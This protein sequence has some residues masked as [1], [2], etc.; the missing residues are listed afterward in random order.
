MEEHRRCTTPPRTVNSGTSDVGA[1]VGVKI[2]ARLEQELVAA[3]PHAVRT[4]AQII[5]DHS[6]AEEAVGEAL[7]AAVVHVSDGGTI[8]HARAWLAQTA[9]YKAIDLVRARETERKYLARY[10]SRQA[11][12]T[13]DPT[14]VVDDA[15][16]ANWFRREARDLPTGTQRVLA[17]LEQADTTAEVAA[18]LGTSKRAVDSQLYRARQKL[19]TVWATTLGILLGIGARFRRACTVAAPTTA[20]AALTLLTLPLV[21]ATG[22]HSKDRTAPNPDAERSVVT[23]PMTPS[24]PLTTQPPAV[25]SSPQAATNPTS[26]PTPMQRTIVDIQ[27]PVNHPRAY[28]TTRPGSEDPILGTL[29][30][31]E[32]IEV[33]PGTHIG[34]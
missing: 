11:E 34:C 8:S 10:A 6:D 18:H 3:M 14:V 32:Q 31:V 1:L 21:T 17:E 15:S 33:K 13:D 25:G 4:C 22:Q 24:R 29:E 27:T 2:P 7:E 20:L 28:E 5:G 12:T 26:A 9:A 30:C 23:T 16:E 19:L